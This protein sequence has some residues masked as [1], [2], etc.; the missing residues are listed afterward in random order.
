MIS[1]RLR[2]MI[3]INLLSYLFEFSSK[4]GHFF[5]IIVLSLTVRYKNNIERQTA[6]ELCCIDI[7]VM[8]KFK[9]VPDSNIW[10]LIGPKD[11][12]KIS[13]K[14]F[15]ENQAWRSSAVL[16]VVDF[17]KV[18]SSFDLFELEIT[19]GRLVINY[20]GCLTT[21]LHPIF[22]NPARNYP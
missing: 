16:I 22:L 14:N 5:F 18:F 21:R 3:E 2:S 13:M 11:L 9:K 4:L 12:Q 6:F 10:F 8:N 20:I 19:L 1:K 17:V 7:G 15:L